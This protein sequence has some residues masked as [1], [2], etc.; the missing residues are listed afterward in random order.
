MKILI[1]DDYPLMR[2]KLAEILKDA[3]P[4]AKIK[5]VGNGKEALQQIRNSKWNLV[6]MDINMPG[7]N[8]LETLKEAKQIALETPVLIL[9]LNTEFL[10]AVQSLKS[11][12]SGFLT[13]ESS[14]EEL[15]DAIKE[16]LAGNKYITKAL[17]DKC[18]FQEK[19]EPLNQNKP[20][21]P[22]I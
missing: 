11:G 5:E 13:K 14:S 22:N 19:P 17:A 20:Y 4:S 12:A 16:I 21:K 3:Y 8:G 2:L 10:Y 9:S 18:S 6:L 7:K 15:V 1:A